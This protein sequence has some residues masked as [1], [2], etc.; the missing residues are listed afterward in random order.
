[1]SAVNPAQQEITSPPQA[2][3]DDP[4]AR[5]NEPAWQ[6]LQGGDGDLDATFGLYGSAGSDTIILGSE[7]ITF[8]NEDGS[9]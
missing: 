5:F 4:R 8:E 1:V 2:T 3:G 7:S 9:P 6:R